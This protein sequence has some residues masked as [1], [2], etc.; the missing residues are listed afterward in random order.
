MRRYGIENPYE[1]LKELTRG[2]GG[3]NKASLHA[4]IE[5]LKIPADAKKC[6]ARNDPSKL[7][8]H[9]GRFNQTYLT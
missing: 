8:R 6:T 9:S 2:K 5:T 1:Q 4:F 3:I 7:Y